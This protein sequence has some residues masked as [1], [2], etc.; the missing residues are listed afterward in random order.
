MEKFIR[1]TIDRM[2][3]LD[4]RLGENKQTSEPR[5]IERSPYRI[6]AGV[7]LPP[8]FSNDRLYCLHKSLCRI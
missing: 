3:R 5:Y 4:S 1:S 6:V 7:L 2:D 8:D